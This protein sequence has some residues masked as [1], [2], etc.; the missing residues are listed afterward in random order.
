MS[1]PFVDPAGPPHIKCLRCRAI[2]AWPLD[3]GQEE[4]A[5]LYALARRDRLEAARY[6]ETVLGLEPKV[7]VPLAQHASESEHCPHCGRE[8][9][10]GDS[11][12]LC[13]ATNVKW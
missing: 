6:A 7:A 12:C 2:V 9:P 8:P 4:A 13:R 10:R 3:L 1:L 5:H 11:L